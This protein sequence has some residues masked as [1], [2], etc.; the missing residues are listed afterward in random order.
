MSVAFRFGLQELQDVKAALSGE[1]SRALK[2]EAEL[3][4]ARQ[5]LDAVHEL[6]KELARYRTPQRAV[7]GSGATSA[8]NSW[9]CEPTLDAIDWS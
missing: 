7:A 2:L 8:D 9:Q 1:Q 3:A 5:R 4:E 6:E